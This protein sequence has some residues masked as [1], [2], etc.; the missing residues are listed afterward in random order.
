MGAANDELRFLVE[1]CVL[2]ALG[3]WG[4][5]TGEGPVRWLLG[6]ARPCWPQW[7]GRCS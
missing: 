5:K 2:G 6:R 7:S 3:Y 1:L 4:F